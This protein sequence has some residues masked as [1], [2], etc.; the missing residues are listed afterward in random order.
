M[1]LL[2]QVNAPPE[3]VVAHAQAL[4]AAHNQDPRFEMLLAFAYSQTGQDARN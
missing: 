2:A 1:M 4:H 3:T